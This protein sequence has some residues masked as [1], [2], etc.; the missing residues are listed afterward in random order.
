MKPCSTLCHPAEPCFITECGTCDHNLEAIEDWEERS[1]IMEYDAE[2]P[3]PNAESL[4]LRDL[5][6]RRG[7]DA[8]RAVQEH[9]RK[10]ECF[11]NREGCV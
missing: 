7:Q 9:R 5:V 6:A 2:L 1:A 8:G 4:A 3:R 11:H 10:K